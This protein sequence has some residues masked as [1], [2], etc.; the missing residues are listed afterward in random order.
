[1]ND[2]RDRGLA[3]T[4]VQRL[5]TPTSSYSNK[6]PASPVKKQKQAK[7]KILWWLIGLIP[8][9]VGILLAALGGY[10]HIDWLV[11]VAVQSLLLWVAIYVQLW[12]KKVEDAEKEN[13]V[14]E[15]RGE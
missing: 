13:K 4:P 15:E 12:L 11:Q 2:E 6:P 5:I 1:V 9:G 8:A 7:G 3:A 14:K 10:Y